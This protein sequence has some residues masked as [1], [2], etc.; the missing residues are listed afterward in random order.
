MQ[1]LE[2]GHGEWKGVGDANQRWPADLRPGYGSLCLVLVLGAV[3]MVLLPLRAAE[4]QERRPELSQCWG[5][6]EPY[7]PGVR[8]LCHELCGGICFVREEDRAERVAWTRPCPVAGRGSLWAFFSRFVTGSKP[9]FGKILPDSGVGWWMDCRSKRHYEEPMDTG[10]DL[11]KDSKNGKEEGH[12]DGR[13]G[14][15]H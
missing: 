9:C 15:P 2:S 5:N 6:S 4:Q 11:E 7:S 8:R 14:R 3:A 12:G 10:I 1:R 13:L